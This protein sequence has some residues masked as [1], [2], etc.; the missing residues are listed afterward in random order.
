MS[1]KVR[2]CEN[3]KAHTN[4]SESLINHRR[5]NEESPRIWTTAIGLLCGKAV[6]SWKNTDFF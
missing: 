4:G 5:Q 2:K 1:D 3:T 6:W